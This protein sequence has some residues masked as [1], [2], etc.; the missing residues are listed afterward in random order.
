MC[1]LRIHNNEKPYLCDMEGCNRRFRTST[2][3]HQHQLQHTVRNLS[4]MKCR[5]NVPLNVHSQVAPPLSAQNACW[6]LISAVIQTSSFGQ[7]VR[8]RPSP[9]KCN[10]PGC[11]KV[12]AYRSGLLAHIKSVHDQ[13][14]S[15]R[16]PV[17][18]CRQQF[19]NNTQLKEHYERAHPHLQ[20]TLV[21]SRTASS[22]PYMQ[23]ST[24][25]IDNMNRGMM[26]PLSTQPAVINAMSM[27]NNSDLRQEG[28]MA[29]IPSISDVIEKQQWC[30]CLKCVTL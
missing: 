9:H 20:G 19:M 3:L 29:D 17:S 16:C 7:E 6:S 26:A 27:R 14:Q 24:I 11:G 25:Q 18:G 12:F 2:Q 10:I 4:P 8:R 15:V 23:L 5:E 30:V 1:H 21:E 22:F 13:K 28:V